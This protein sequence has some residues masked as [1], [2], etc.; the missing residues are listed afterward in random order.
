MN[1]LDGAGR[2]SAR[3][4][5]T[6]R[7]TLAG[8]QGTGL[9]IGVIG[10]GI[11][12]LGAAY[13]LA[14]HHEVQ[15]FEREPRL[16]GHAHTHEIPAGTRTLAL[17]TGFLV[18]NERTYPSFVTLLRQLGV[19]G[20]PSDM[21]FGVRCRRCGLEYSTRTLATLFAQPHRV[22]DPGFLRMLADILRFFRHARALLAADADEGDGMTLGAFLARHRYGEGFAPHFLLPLVGAVWS[23][24]H[25]DVRAFPIRPLLRFM[26]NHGMLS[27]TDNPQWLTIRG[28]S[29]TYVDALARHLEGRIHRGRPVLRVVRRADSVDIACADGRVERVDKVVIATHADEA[30]ALLAD[31][32]DTEIRLLRSF[33]YSANRTVL[34]T[35]VDA[36][37]RHRSAWA[38]WN[39]DIDDCRDA[40]A[41]VSI[42]YHL[43]RL[44]SIAGPVQY[45][46]SLN[47]RRPVTGPVLAVMDYT[48]PILDGAAVA[49]QPQL[50]ALNGTRHTYYCGA[51]LRYGFHEDG[52]VSALDVAAAFGI[53]L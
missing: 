17:D 42:T 44:Q 11:S 47:R 33:R 22:V 20:Q 7:H 13:L 8:V 16:G 53:A 3:S 12:G 18:Y 27:A 14:R 23:A 9:R 32:S 31:P 2:P 48:H 24:S 4:R 50:R 10:A 28:G 37:P 40:T 26:D 41:P 25:D 1:L 35:D 29:R 34:H 19:E 6:V 45:C 49:A 46:V 5:A 39:A 21:S 15:V 36:L 38:S 52:L 30:L 51:H 43:N